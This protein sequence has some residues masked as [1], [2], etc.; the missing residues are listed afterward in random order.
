MSSSL[1]D[2]SA[3]REDIGSIEIRLYLFLGHCF[4]V[5]DQ[6]HAPVVLSLEMYLQYTPDRMDR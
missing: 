1:R 3:S 4:N 5:N 2:E 6:F